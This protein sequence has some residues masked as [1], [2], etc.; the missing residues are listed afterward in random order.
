[1]RTSRGGGAVIA[2]AGVAL[3][4]WLGR[5]GTSL[6]RRAGLAFVAVAVRHAFVLNAR[7]RAA[8]A[9]TFYERGLRRLDDTWPGTGETGERFRSEHHPYADDLDLFG[10]G[11]LFELLSSPRT[12][13]GEATLAGW[14]LTPAAPEV[15]RDR[16]AGRPGAGAQDSI[17]G[18]GSSSSGPTCA[19]SWTPTPCGS[20][21]CS[22]A[23]GGGL[24]ALRAAG[25]CRADDRATWRGGSGPASRPAG[26][27]R[28][29][30]C[31]SA[32]GLVVPRR[33]REVSEHV[34]RRAQE[35]GVLRDLLA[36]IEREPAA[37]PRLQTLAA[38]LTA[39][40]HVPSVEIGRLV[41]LADLLNTRQNQFFVPIAALL[42]LGT[43]TAM[44]IDRWRERCGRARAALARDRRRVRSAG[45][46]G[47]LCGRAPRRRAIR[48]IEDDGPVLEADAAC[49]PAD[50]RRS[51]R[52]ERPAARR[53]RP[54]TCCW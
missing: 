31:Q 51:R 53:R 44:A 23:A 37:S 7:D 1:M 41:R 10:R 48:R 28:C 8:R 9:V 24:A 27:A 54:R 43:Q 14:L 45:R 33:V 32:V 13:A 52:A 18:K 3:I 5:P 30:S 35:L 22:A 4:V 46:A 17:S 6:A 25:P 16:A 47:R 34:E 39:T 42:L 26:W 36:L 49:P 2:A 21:R 15:I 50:S 11:S 20:G 19:P 40:G 38:E 29:W 12:A